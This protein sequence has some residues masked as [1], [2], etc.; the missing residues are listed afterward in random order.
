LQECCL[1]SPVDISKVVRAGGALAAFA[2]IYFLNPASLAIQGHPSQATGVFVTE[3][4][5]DRNLVEYFWKQADVRFRFPSDGWKISTKAA[6]VG[7]GDMTLQHSSGKDA[8]IQ[9][10]VSILDDKY[11][12]NWS[13][14]E[15]N[16]VGIWKGTISQ[17]GPF[18]SREVFVDGRSAFR[19]SG[20]RGEVQGL[21]KIDLIY[22]PLG[23]NRLL[24]IHLTRNDD[25]QHNSDLERAFDLIISTIQFVR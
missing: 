5:Q 4:P 22:A 2:A 21:K 17:F 19:I 1:G 18:S 9:L 10:H 3:L 24:E 23:D 13:Q 6:E 15:R 11:R 8:Q 20:V 16:T 7:L 12:D 14:F 25:N